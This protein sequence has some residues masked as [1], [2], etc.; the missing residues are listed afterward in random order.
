MAK[1]YFSNSE[2]GTI[3]R[4]QR[5]ANSCGFY[6]NNTGVYNIMH[7]DGNISLPFYLEK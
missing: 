3:T 4:T 6:A 2:Y 5:P 1:S 7:P